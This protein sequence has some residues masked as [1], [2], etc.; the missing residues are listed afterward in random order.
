MCRGK[1]QGLA[2]PCTW[3]GA[4]DRIFKVGKDHEDPEVQLN[5]TVPT[6]RVPG[7]PISVVVAYLWAVSSEQGLEPLSLVQG[8]ESLRV[9]QG[10][11]PKLNPAKV[12][13]RWGYSSA[14]S[15]LL[16]SNL[17]SLS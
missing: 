13:S 10:F 2:S 9:N 5:P 3:E 8:Q 12:G 11:G 4:D 17:A 7:C 16:V 15:Y 6:D 1:M 14:F